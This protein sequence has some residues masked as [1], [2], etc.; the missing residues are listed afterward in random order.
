MASRNPRYAFFLLNVFVISL[1]S[2]SCYTYETLEFDINIPEQAESSI[3]LASDGTLITTLVAPE[4]RTSARRLE[5]IPEIARNAVIAIEDERFYKHDG[6]DLKGILRA[7]RSNL[8]AGGISQGGSTITQQYVKLAIIENVEQTASRKLEELWYATRLE[9]EY[10]KDFILL[11]YLNT[12]YFGHGAYGI[13]A[14]AQTYF[15]KDINEISIYEAALLAG[16]LKAPSRYDPFRNYSQS[17]RRSHLVLDRMVANGFITTEQ[18][19]E[20]TS[21]PPKLEEYKPR[22]ETEYPAGH[23]V[24]EVR[25]WFLE[26]PAFGAN[27]SIREMLLYEGGVR[28]ETTIDLDLQAA[29]EKAVENHLPS[30][31]NLPDASVVVI[32][33][34]TSQIIAM[35]GGRDFF[36]EED[37]A[38]VNLAMGNG[39]QAGSSFKPIGLAAALESGWEVTATYPAPNALEFFIPG[40]DNDNRVWWVSGGLNGHDSDEPKFEKGLMALFQF[41]VREGHVEIPEEHTETIEYRDD[42]EDDPEFVDVRLNEWINNRKW[43]YSMNSLFDYR[44][45]MLE[46]VPGWN[47][48]PIEGTEL[49]PMAEPPMVDLIRATRSS[50]NTVFA[51]LS[52]QMGAERVVNLARRLGVKSPIQPVNSNVLGTSNVTLLDMASAYSTFANRGVYT[53]PSMVTRVTRMDGTPL[54]KW[55][56]ELERALDSKLVDQL[57]WVLEGTITEGTGH[58]AKIGRP[59]AGKTGTTQNYADALF[60]GYTPQI[61]TAVWV[62]YPK[63]QIPMVPPLTERK[64]YGGTFPA[65]IWKDVMLAAHADLP[66]KDFATPPASSTTTVPDKG[67][68]V[69]PELIGLTLENAEL[70]LENDGLGDQTL[71]VIEVTDADSEPGIVLGQSPEAGTSLLD[72]SKILVEVAIQPTET[73][74]TKVPDLVGEVLVDVSPLLASLGLGYEIALIPNPEN[75]NELPEIIWAQNPNPGTMVESGSVISLRMAP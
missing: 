17:L 67:G 71:T 45:K 34:Q 51:Q 69:M 55:N 35:V 59:A 19:E 60:V 7:A 68:L 1:L 33:P 13:K 70:N 53:P 47:W 64:V 18:R 12:V 75:E 16:L 61:A 6:F 22:L 3:V 28:I 42:P 11:Q 73:N 37:D 9:D 31:Q 32:D 72:S 21:S 58:R 57:T 46:D 43:E 20:A 49:I 36:A 29:A 62:G 66:V 39:R 74:K 48:E 52:M 54:W 15:N 2:T 38:K 26:N 50:Y 14:A 23:F 5:E 63:G 41:L 40:A 27:R 65:L 4:N 10:G 24:E 8:E 30:N 56:R 25:K 44:I